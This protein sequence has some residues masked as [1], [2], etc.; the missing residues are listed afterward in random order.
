MA[1]KTTNKPVSEDPLSDVISSESIATSA[2]IQSLQ[3]AIEEYDSNPTQAMGIRLKAEA[4]KAVNRLVGISRSLESLKEALADMDEETE[5]DPTEGAFQPEETTRPLRSSAPMLKDQCPLIATQSQ[6][7]VRLYT[8]NLYPDMFHR[9]KAASPISADQ[10]RNADYDHY[11]F[12]EQDA[13][14]YFHP[15]PSK[16][17]EFA[18]VAMMQR[19]PS[20]HENQLHLY[21]TEGVEIHI[22]TDHESMICTTEIPDMVGLKVFSI[23]RQYKS[24]INHG[25]AMMPLTAKHTTEDRRTVLEE[26]MKQN[27]I[28]PKDV[29]I[30]ETGTDALV[31]KEKNVIIDVS[32][33]PDVPTVKIIKGRKKAEKKVVVEE[34]ETR[35]AIDARRGAISI[36]QQ[37]MEQIIDDRNSMSSWERTVLGDIGIPIE[38]IAGMTP[39]PTIPITPA[40]SIR[41]TSID[42]NP[43]SNIVSGPYIQFP[44]GLSQ[45]GASLRERDVYAS[46][47]FTSVRGHRMRNYDIDGDMYGVGLPTNNNQEYGEYCGRLYVELPETQR[48]AGFVIRR[49]SQLSTFDD[50][51]HRLIKAA[52][53]CALLRSGNYSM[54]VYRI[55]NREWYVTFVQGVAVTDVRPENWHQV[56]L[57]APPYC[58][59]LFEETSQQLQT[60]SMN[61]TPSAVETMLA[62][63][64]QA[65]QNNYRAGGRIT[66][67]NP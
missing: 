48:K 56:N 19:G 37:A 52:Y 61:A 31:A 36:Y 35:D 17:E 21:L 50:W 15:N 64:Y 5:F 4:R 18:T 28:N 63:S 46:G 57:C 66:H 59:P 25:E 22:H 38:A 30:K 27:G 43:L 53:L 49:L 24:L 62:N 1:K 7:A 3:N 23:N 67:N 55:E 54:A 6:V 32:A 16:P 58:D 13:L 26:A 14:I 33:G 20:N 12:I 34:Q 51:Q 65:I 29:F 2:A 44:S 45:E 42:T 40:S 47:S 60:P 8:G 10:M 39:L 11:Q 9:H 41:A